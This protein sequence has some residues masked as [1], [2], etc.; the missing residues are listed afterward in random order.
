MCTLALTGQ[1]AEVQYSTSML[2]TIQPL[3]SKAWLTD[4]VYTCNVHTKNK[5]FSKDRNEATHLFSLQ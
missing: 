3:L 1:R 4:D 5:G 2:V